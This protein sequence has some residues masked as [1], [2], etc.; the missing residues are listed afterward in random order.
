MSIYT[1]SSETALAAGSL[2]TNDLF[3]VQDVSAGALKTVT[4][5]V[6]WSGSTKAVATTATSLSLTKALH[7]NRTVIVNSTAAAAIVLPQATGTGDRY[8]I[9]MGVAA[10]ATTSSIAVA[11]ATDIMRGVIWAATTTSDNAEA[12]IASATSD[13]ITLNGTTK[14]GVIG[15]MYMIT[16]VAT[17]I[18]NVQGFTAPTGTEVTPFSAAV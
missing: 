1:L 15:D 8:T 16:D 14:G 4:W 2:A 6:L 3:P 17:G 12:F 7:A 10:T 11:N 9:V 5:D 13:T 18:F